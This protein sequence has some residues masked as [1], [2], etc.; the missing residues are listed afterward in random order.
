[1]VV[2]DVF[3]NE[4]NYKLRKLAKTVRI[5]AEIEHVKSRGDHILAQKNQTAI[6]HTMEWS[7]NLTKFVTKLMTAP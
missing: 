7:Q 3:R 4:M 2:T 6:F 1:M 5:F